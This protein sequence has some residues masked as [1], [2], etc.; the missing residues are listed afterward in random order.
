MHQLSNFLSVNLEIYKILI[1]ETI[2]TK[3]NVEEETKDVICG[4]GSCTQR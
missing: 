3:L 4:K 1:V 2:H